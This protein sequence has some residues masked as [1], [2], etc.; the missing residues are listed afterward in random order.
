MCACPGNFTNASVTGTRAATHPSRV[1]GVH[2]TVR[3]DFAHGRRVQPVHQR[4]DAG[5]HFVRQ[6]GSHREAVGLPRVQAAAVQA[7]RG[8]RGGRV[9]APVR[10]VRAGG[11]QRRHRVHRGVLRGRA[12]GAQ[13]VRRDQL[14]R[15][16]VQRL[17]PHVRRG[18]RN[19]GGRLLF[20]LAQETVHVVRPQTLGKT[21]VTVVRATDAVP[22]TGGPSIFTVSHPRPSPAVMLSRAARVPSVVLSTQIMF[23]SCRHPVALL[24]IRFGGGLQF[25]FTKNQ[26]R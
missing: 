26:T 24:G 3:R 4:L 25:F 21:R 1:P 18:R 5:V 7:V 10:A 19:R 17:R 16:A 11:V 12:G 22:R 20:H 15:D 9:A 2:R 23:S 6:V 13:D 14:L 8:E